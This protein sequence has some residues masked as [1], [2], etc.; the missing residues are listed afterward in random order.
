M[1]IRFIFLP[2]LSLILVPALSF[3]QNSSTEK[4]EELARHQIISICEDCEV[5]V[6]PKWIPNIIHG[7]EPHQITNIRFKQ[8]GLPKGYQTASVFYQ[9]ND[10]DH[11]RDVQIHIQIKKPLPVAT[12][13]IE[14]N[15]MISN[16]DLMERMTDITRLQRMPIDSKEEVLSQSA[17]GII[18]KGNVFYNSNLQRKPVI[19]AGDLVEMIYAEGG[20]EVALN[21]DAREDKAKGEN[22]RVY[23]EK[24][25]KTYVGKVLNAEKVLWEK[26]L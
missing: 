18:K 16:D 25:R 19:K 24:T 10:E 23:S 8:V 7:L 21:C 22:I 17:A 9:E 12:R 3:A 5:S 11:S 6:T 2:V 20:V 26:T 13:R 4:I 14:R 15:E 1:K